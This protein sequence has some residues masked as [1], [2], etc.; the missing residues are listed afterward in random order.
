MIDKPICRACGIELD[1]ENWYKSYKKGRS[2]ICKQCVYEHTV[3][4]RKANPE[5]AMAQ[6]RL[7]RK[8]NPDKVKL[9][10][11]R[12]HRKQGARPFDENKECSS[13]LGVHVAERVLKHV[14]KNV[15]TMPIGNRGYDFICNR[16]KK[17]DV[18]SSCIRK[19]LNDWVFG[20]K[21][22]TIAD[23]FLCLAFDDRENLNPMHVWLLPGETFNHLS[24]A[25][26]RPST[27]QRWD[28]YKLDVNSVIS[29]CNT[30][31]GV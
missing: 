30:I 15:E 24:S 3:S 20:I 18:K 26:I 4:W 6:V 17:I 12:S 19:N 21:R 31:R 27:L 22:N 9:S 16:G 29:C 2:Y 25:G 8:E 13:Y 14:F 5:K 10:N 28:E 11:T 7:W 23:Y 1:D